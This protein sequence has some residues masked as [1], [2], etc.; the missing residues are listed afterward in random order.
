MN[1]IKRVILT[2]IFSFI[3]LSV[4]LSSKV[5]AQEWT[6]VG[7]DTERIPEFS[8]YSSERYI[9]NNT[10]LGTAANHS[11]YEVVKGNISDT[12]MG[13]PN[14]L[15]FYENFTNGT[16]IYINLYYW[17]ATSD[18]D[19]KSYQ[20]EWQAF[21]WNST[22]YLG[23]GT[24]IPIDEIIGEVSEDILSDFS[25]FFSLMLSQVNV[26]FENNAVY[27]NS[28]SVQLWNVTYNNAY[29]K[30]NFTESGI[31]TKMEGYLI[32]NMFN[33]TLYSKPAQFFYG[34]RLIYSQFYR[35]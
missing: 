26:T 1:L 30:V 3:I 23:I 8:V 11:I 9:Y 15:P 19:P 2:V 22:T 16:C 14:Y 17:N 21:Y 35:I 5:S 28:F 27:S 10:Y 24:F 25:Y 18:Q 34:I 13:M 33:M 32:S 29:F 6:Y 20:R 12:F 7:I 4:F 31:L